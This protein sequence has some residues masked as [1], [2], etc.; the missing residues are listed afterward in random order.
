MPQLHGKGIEAGRAPDAQLGRLALLRGQQRPH[1][2]G[3]AHR[4]HARATDDLYR[5][6]LR[7]GVVKELV[8]GLHAAAPGQ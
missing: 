2:H 1:A 7:G 3:H 4:L 5:R 6:A 8:A